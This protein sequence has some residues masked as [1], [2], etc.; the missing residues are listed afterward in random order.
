MDKGNIYIKILKKNI[1]EIGI[2]IKN[3]EKVHFFILRN[4]LISNRRQILRKFYE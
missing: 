1:R 2:T 4:C 3:K